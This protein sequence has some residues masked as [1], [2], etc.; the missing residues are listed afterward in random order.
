MCAFEPNA[1]LSRA[2]Q[3][4]FRI[5]QLNAA[6]IDFSTDPI[7][8]RYGVAPPLPRRRAP[9]VQRWYRPRVRLEESELALVKAHFQLRRNTAR[10][11]RSRGLFNGV[12]VLC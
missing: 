11:A 8:R 2:I 4:I 9:R 7:L 10:Y 1:G 3:S 5:A 6:T 12:Y